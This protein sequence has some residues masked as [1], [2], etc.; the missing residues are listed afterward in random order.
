MMTDERERTRQRD[1]N[2]R[3]ISQHKEI[4]RSAWPERW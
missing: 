3:K 4:R 2:V 1:K